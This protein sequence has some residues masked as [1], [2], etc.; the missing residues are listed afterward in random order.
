MYP[1][2]LFSQEVEDGVVV[3]VSVLIIVL[4]YILVLNYIY[5]YISGFF[6]FDAFIMNIHHEHIISY[7][8]NI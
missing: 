5:I 6:K 7:V 2:S 8:D 3:V 1:W 4:H